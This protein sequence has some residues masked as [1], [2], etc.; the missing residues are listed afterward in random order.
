MCVWIVCVIVHK[1]QSCIWTFL[2]LSVHTC[3][4]VQVGAGSAALAD[5]RLFGGWGVHRLI[6][7]YHHHLCQVILSPQMHPHTHAAPYI[8]SHNPNPNSDPTIQSMGCK[9]RRT[10]W[11][12]M[13]SFLF[14]C[15]ILPAS[16]FHGPAGFGYFWSCS[17]MRSHL[18]CCSMCPQCISVHLQKFFRHMKVFSIEGECPAP[19]WL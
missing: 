9:S 7:R 19:R 3:R 16:G 5:C 6:D 11:T 15:V 10:W 1:T 8:I 17:G 14:A 12:F 18:H 13:A 2:C 4:R